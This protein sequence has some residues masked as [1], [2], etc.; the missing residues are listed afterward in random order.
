MATAHIASTAV[1]D[2]VVSLSEMVQGLYNH[3][4]CCTLLFIARRHKGLIWCFYSEGKNMRAMNP[5]S[6]RITLRRRIIYK[7]IRTL[8]QPIKKLLLFGHRHFCPI[9]QSR[10]RRF[11]RFVPHFDTWCP[12]CGSLERQRLV[13]IFLQQLTDFLSPRPKKLLHIAPEKALEKRFKQ[14]ANVQYLSGDL[15]PYLRGDLSPA[16]LRMDI[17]DIRQPHN[18]FDVII[19]NHVL[20]GIPNDRRAM[21]EFYRIL[22]PGGFAVLTEPITTGKTFEDLTVVSPAERERVFGHHEYVRQYGLDIT[23]RLKEAGFSVRTFEER[24]LVQEDDLL[25]LGVLQ[26]G[27]EDTASLSQPLFCCEKRADTYT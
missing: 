7:V 22:K 23:D 24:E 25:R 3:R 26:C 1:T 9:C 21:Q 2:T 18:S 8:P 15:N 10:I 16:M 11:W 6:E 27:F 19:C 5:V 17:T 13:W 20:M 12:V 14:C 4:S